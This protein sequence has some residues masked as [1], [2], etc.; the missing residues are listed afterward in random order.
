MPLGTR[1]GRQRPRVPEVRAARLVS[2][3]PPLAWPDGGVSTPL[4]PRLL[5]LVEKERKQNR[6]ERAI[7]RGREVCPPGARGSARRADGTSGSRACGAATAAAAAS[8]A[9]SGARVRDRGPRAA[10]VRFS[11]PF[12]LLHVKTQKFLHLHLRNAADAEGTQ[13]LPL[14]L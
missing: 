8:Q 10:Q 4:R 6:E 12:Q 2:Y 14:P 11:V 13:V 5:A 9:R 1:P 7:Y 3:V